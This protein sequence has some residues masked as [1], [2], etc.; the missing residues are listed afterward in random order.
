M[1]KSITKI[2]IKNNGPAVITAENIIIEQFDGKELKKNI[3]R[4][5]ICRCG[6]SKEMPF[7]DGAHK[8][9]SFEN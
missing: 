8:H 6:M 9:I 3:E 4:I 1:E 5:S 2:I 7:C